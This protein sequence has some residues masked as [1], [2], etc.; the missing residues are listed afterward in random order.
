[1]KEVSVQSKIYRK[2]TRAFYE[3]DGWQTG[4]RHWRAKVLVH[5]CLTPVH[6]LHLWWSHGPS[7]HRGA[8]VGCWQTWLCSQYWQACSTGTSCSLCQKPWRGQRMTEKGLAVV[9]DTFPAVDVL[10][11]SCRL[12]SC[13][14][15]TSPMLKFS[16]FVTNILSC[17]LKV[18]SWWRPTSG[19]WN[20]PCS[21]WVQSLRASQLDSSNTHFASQSLLR[22]MFLTASPTQCRYF[23]SEGKLFRIKGNWFHTPPSLWAMRS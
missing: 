19:P 20:P 4:G 17:S 5:T 7:F 1:M 9:P 14:C 8:S 2:T 11:I 15:E 23:P 16:D 10:W 21:V 6:T 3:G 18:R 12:Y 22:A 13:F